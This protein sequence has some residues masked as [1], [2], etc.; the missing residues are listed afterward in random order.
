[1]DSSG[2]SNSRISRTLYW[3]ILSYLAGFL[4]LK[5]K[6]CVLFISWFSYLTADVAFGRR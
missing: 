3:I 1:M 2:T 5:T 4:S 6:V